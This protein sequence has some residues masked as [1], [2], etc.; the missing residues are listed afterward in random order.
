MLREVAWRG[1]VSISIITSSLT[2]LGASADIAGG[3]IPDDPIPLPN[4]SARIL[5][6]VVEYCQHHHEHP[7]AP[8]DK[9]DEKRTDDILPWDLDFCKVDQPT[10]FEL[11]LVRYLSL[12]LWA[13]HS[14]THPLH[15]PPT[16]STSSRCSISRA[17]RLPT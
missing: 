5:E 8:S 14:L 6:K 4:V 17:R 16:T 13:A 2:L 3:E 7:T 11:I 1:V 15:R 12:L 10:L 9:A